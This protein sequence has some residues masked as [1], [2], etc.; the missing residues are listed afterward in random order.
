MDKIEN[1]FNFWCPI[2]KSKSIDPTTGETI[3]RLG[4][5]ASTADEDSDGEFLDPK[6][7]DIRPLLKSG[8]VNWHHQAK[9]QPATIIGEPSKAEI[10]PQGLYIETDL[11]PSSKIA[12]EVWELAETLEKDSKNRRLGYSI[13]GRVVKRKSDDPKNPDYKKVEK[14]IITGVAITHQPKNPKTFASIIK[15]DIDDFDDEIEEAI[16]ADGNGK[17]L[18]KES[19]DKKLKVQTFGKAEVFDQIFRHLPDIS[20]EKAKKIHIMLKTLAEMNGRKTITDEDIQKA[21]DALGL[22]VSI[23]DIQKGEN[24]KADGGEKKILKGKSTKKS[25]DDDFDGEEGDESEEN[26]KE[27]EDK[28]KERL[29]GIEGDEKLHEEAEKRKKV[30]KGGMNERF[31][32]IEKAIGISHAEQTNFIRSL[33][34]LIKSISSKVDSLTEDNVEL[35]EIVKAQ[36]ETISKLM[37]KIDEFGSEVPAPKSISAARPVQRAFAKANDNDFSEGSNSL[38]ENQVSSSNRKAITNILDQACFAKG[39]YDEEF[40]KACVSY[41]AGAPLSG[42]IINRL[43][44]EFGIEVVK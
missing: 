24:C 1:R 29:G 8:L 30:E 6:G 19:V 35:S 9:G 41:E 5:I 31:D 26:V 16:E 2:E 7:F 37:D 22:D 43:K 33:G 42:N 23:L 32:V 3:M 12:Q 10:T 40:G 20:I 18:K 14:A 15:G 25:D 11:Y 4:G 17:P 44:Y 21:F 38:K 27:R 13:E 36:E 28:L 39:G 34:V